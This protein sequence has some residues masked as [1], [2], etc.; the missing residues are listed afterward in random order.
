VRVASQRVRGQASL[1]AVRRSQRPLG[2]RG[3]DAAEAQP[4]RREGAEDGAVARRVDGDHSGGRGARLV[5]RRRRRRRSPDVQQPRVPRWVGRWA[6]GWAAFS[7]A[8]RAPCA[9]AA[10]FGVWILIFGGPWARD[11]ALFGLRG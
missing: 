6:N 8:P 11:C 7:S 3:R 5:V 1:A 4:P 2:R 9:R 10:G